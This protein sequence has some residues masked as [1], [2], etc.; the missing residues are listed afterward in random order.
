MFLNKQ[1]IKQGCWTAVEE[2]TWKG[3]PAIRK[4]Y[5]S[6]QSIR[7][8][9]EKNNL[10]IMA[11]TDFGLFVNST[12]TNDD[13]LALIF[14]YAPG[15]SGYDA[16]QNENPLATLS[17]MIESIVDETARMKKQRKRFS[18]VSEGYKIENSP[19]TYCNLLVE[20]SII[21]TKQKDEL[22]KLLQIPRPDP[23]WGRYDP[24]LSNLIVSEQ[25][26]SH[27]D[28]ESMSIQDIL[29]PLAY[30]YVH[31]ELASIPSELKKIVG[32]GNF[33]RTAKNCAVGSLCTNS[34]FESRMKLNIAEVCGYIILETTREKPRYL[35]SNKNKKRVDD[36][37][38]ILYK[39]LSS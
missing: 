1:T 34:E 39:I 10:G 18:F 7:Y 25:G 28:Y 26:V 36:S 19:F 31:I 4:M 17:S 37:K 38:R 20:S 30:A 32:N 9:A 2:G 11:N 22:K 35:L 33:I 24:E 15:K 5:T 29:Y 13:E 14:P 6:N 12:D 23:V 27:I 16:L 21:D 3:M 8:H